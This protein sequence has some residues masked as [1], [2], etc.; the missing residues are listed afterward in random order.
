MHKPIF[1]LLFISASLACAQQVDVPQE[2]R[3]QYQL[4]SRAEH[5]RSGYL[6]RKE[7]ALQSYRNCMAA[8][9]RKTQSNPHACD[10]FLTEANYYGNMAA[11]VRS[12]ANPLTGSVTDQPLPPRGSTRNRPGGIIAGTV[13]GLS[14]NQTRFN[15]NPGTISPDPAI[16]SRDQ[17]DNSR[18]TGDWRTYANRGRRP[19]TVAPPTQNPSRRAP[20]VNGS[21]YRELPPGY[22]H[23]RNRR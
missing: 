17:I 11:A 9:Q 18:G 23:P 10:S 4:Q 15:T 21:G 16:D 13:Y 19:H 22:Y 1:S 2:Q 12:S 7:A 3:Q 5:L 8:Q 20:G 6:S 14:T